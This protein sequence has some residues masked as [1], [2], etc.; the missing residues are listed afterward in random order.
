MTV[1]FGDELACI[2]FLTAVWVAER[3]MAAAG[4]SPLLGNFIAGILLGPPLADM[5]PHSDAWRLIGKLGV[6]I[7]I[8]D[9]TL[10]IDLAQVRACGGRAFAAAAAGVAGPVGLSMLVISAW[11]GRPWK[12]ALAAGA[13]LAPTSLGF[14]AKLLQEF[15]QLQTPLGQLICVA[16]VMDDVLS[17]CLLAEI[18]A[19]KGD[20]PSSWDIAKPLV[21]SFG[22]ILIGGVLA[23]SVFPRA[24][25]PVLKCLPA[26]GPARN[27]CLVALVLTTATALA[28]AGAGAG[29]SDLLGTFA[30]VLPFSAFPEVVDAWQRSTKPLVQ[31]GGR[32]FFSATVGFGTP[33][34]RA[35]D[36]NMLSGAAVWKGAALGV[37]AIAGKF[38][39]GPFATPRTSANVQQFGWAMQGRGEFSFLLA[40]EAAEDELFEAGSADHPSVIW[41]L[42]FA[43]LAAPFAFRMTLS[44]AKKAKGGDAAAETADAEMASPS[45][46]TPVQ[47]PAPAPAPVPPPAAGD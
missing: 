12:T 4:G 18:K 46:Q 6:L 28:F 47:A 44:S 45:S 14:S 8:V 29:S 22:S 41:G 40:D 3:T 20:D 16:A 15:G 38:L 30:G 17:L 5:V 7:L 13:A 42:L 35:G 10:T 1:P 37:A 9:G 25:P 39:C 2:G 32:L 21:A 23:L 24:L 26:D 33:K 19:L 36:G 43:C 11:F 34:V 27:C 31:W